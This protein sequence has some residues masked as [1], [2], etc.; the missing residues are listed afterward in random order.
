MITLYELYW[1]HYCEKIRWALDYKKLPWREI[2]INAFTKREMKKFPATQ[3]R[4]LVPLIHDSN[5][6]QSI[7]DSSPI[8]H[9]LENTYPESP[10]L[11][12]NDIAEKEKLYKLLIELDSK[13]AVIARRLGYTQLILEN[14]KILSRLFLSDIGNGFFNLPAIRKIS[15]ACLGMLLIKRFGFELSESLFLYEELEMYLLSIAQ[16]LQSNK[17]LFNNTFSAA[18]I[19]L[20]VYLRPLRIVPFFIDNPALAGL[21]EWQKNLLKEHNR[22]EKLLY[23]ILIEEHRKHHAPVRR[24]IRNFSDKGFLHQIEQSIN[25]IKTAYND[26][27]P[28]WTWR[29]WCVP[30]Y[31]FF[32]IRRNKLRQQHASE[33]VR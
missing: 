20:A 14:P 18:D 12:P 26:H 17:F 1:S 28:L 22:E 19:S 25:T 5:T 4:H 9:Y 24:Y 13:L 32:K 8:L 7:S 3:K 31:Y 6:N 10:T 2:N 16:K 30:Y 21:F 33:T 23:E 29:M 27:H 11:F 15:S